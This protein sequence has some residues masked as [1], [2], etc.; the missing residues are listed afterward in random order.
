MLPQASQRAQALIHMLDRLGVGDAVLG[1]QQIQGLLYAMACSPEPIRPREW[2]ELIWLNDEAPFADNA[3]A[4][5]FYQLLVDLAQTI[6]EAADR[7]RYQP[8]VDRDGRRSLESLSAWC[9]GLLIGHHYLEHVWTIA[10]DDLDDDELY[11][12]VN[13]VLQWAEFL[14]SIETPGE[15]VAE[16]L[17][18]TQLQFEEWLVAYHAV[19]DRWYRGEFSWKVED[20][21]RDMQPVAADAACPCGSGRPFGSCCLH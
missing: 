14:A 8:G 1:Y 20:H 12:Q 18:T 21:F 15:E 16:Q 17:A 13:A 3:E 11:E 6:R 19:R 10:L 5:S 7:G 4:H 9:E 2:F